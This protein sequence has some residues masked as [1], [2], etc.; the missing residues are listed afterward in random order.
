MKRPS[1]SRLRLAA[2]VGELRLRRRRRRRSARRRPRDR[3]RRGIYLLPSLFTVANLFCGFSSLAF[4][5]DGDYRRSA[6][7]VIAAIVFDFLDGKVARLTGTA[8]DFGVQLD[9]LSDVI[10]FGVAPA[11]LLYT[12]SLRSIGRGGWLVAFIYVVSGASRLARFNIQTSTLA[13]SDFVGLPI[14]AGAGVLATIVFVFPSPP[15]LPG[16]APAMLLLMG[17]IAFLQVSTIR[18]PSFKGARWTTRVPY[19]VIVLLAVGLA[20]IAY[21]PAEAL[22][23]LSLCYMASGPLLRLFSRKG[24]QK[25]SA[26]VSPI[27]ENAT[28]SEPLEPIAGSAPPA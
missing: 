27:Q 26:E 7:F 4:S 28:G 11:L 19:R 3:F 20:V 18:Y 23:C 14:P 22:L 2:G 21:R 8:S 10:S 25:A 5:V 24:G 15:E 16:W 1:G 13:S 12:W 9:S 17:A 6:F